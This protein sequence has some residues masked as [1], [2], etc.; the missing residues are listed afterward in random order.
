MS[1]VGKLAT[2]INKFRGTMILE[3][4]P[5]AFVMT[6]LDV[7][8]RRNTTH[9]GTV[10]TFP[11]ERGI[12][13]ADNFHL[14]PTELIVEGIISDTPVQYF[15][16]LRTGPNRSLGVYDYLIGLQKREAPVIVFTDIRIHSDMVLEVI[17]VDEDADTG[18]CVP[19]V[20]TFRESPVLTTAFVPAVLDLDAAIAGAGGTVNFGTQSTAAPFDYT[21]PTKL[22]NPF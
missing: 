8:T 17:A 19:L 12:N 4:S 2:L 11:V 14:N 9:P 5:T 7:T 13:G 6:E 20:L 16:G 21:G 1:F 18:D 3:M 15:S 22:I 10:A